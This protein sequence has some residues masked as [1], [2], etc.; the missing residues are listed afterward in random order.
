MYSLED[1]REIVGDEII[2]TIHRKARRLYGKHIL[3]VNSTYQGGGVAEMLSSIVPLMNDIGIVAGWRILH[4]TPDFFTIT[5]KF[6]NA[7][8]GEPINF[9]EMKK[10]LYI[11]A[12]EDF[13]V[14]THIDHDCIIIH[15]PQPLPLIKF[16]KK[17]QPWIWRCHIDL[18]TPNKELWDF[19]KKFVLRYDIVIISSEKYKREDLPVEQRVIHPAIDPLSPKNIEIPDG[20]ISKY[21]KKFG[22]PKD[23]PLITQISRFDKWKDPEGVIEVFKLVRKEVDCRLV[24]C[25]STAAD[26]PE[27]WMIYERVKRKARRLIEN[28]D[29]LLTTSENNIFV[30]ALQRGSAVLIQKSI[31]EGF[32]LTVTE[33]LWKGKPVVASNT[34]GI[35]LQIK[36]GESGFLVD[37]Y[38]TKTFAE[39]IIQIL[40]DPDLAEEMGK[41]GKEMVRKNFL[42]TRLLSDYLDLL[43]DVI[44]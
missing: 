33:A 10:R 44:K 24:L 40:Q 16:Y 17:R 4:G 25:G 5:K 35:P 8:Q 19:L 27:G 42:T 13:S 39:R 14:Y 15:D 7:L 12:N 23:K 41:K 20:V 30:N 36:D 2:S 11:Q 28:K 6:H 26:D 18:S 29:V 43:N 31:R 21:L 38:D 37:P 32:G 34:G 3:H 9:T 1:Y 22:I